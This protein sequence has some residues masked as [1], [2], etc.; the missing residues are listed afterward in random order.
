MCVAMVLTYFATAYTTSRIFGLLAWFPTPAM[1]LVQPIYYIGRWIRVRKQL[2]NHPELSQQTGAM[3]HSYPTSVN[4]KLAT[5]MW[6]AE[7]K[8]DE[9]LHDIGTRLGKTTKALE[10]IGQSN[11]FEGHEFTVVLK[12]KIDT[13]LK[14]MHKLHGQLKEQKQQLMATIE[15]YQLQLSEVIAFRDVILAAEIVDDNDAFLTKIETQMLH[16]EH[17][18]KSALGQIQHD[19]LSVNMLVKSLGEVQELYPAVIR[20]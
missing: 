17:G 9:L 7:S 12:Q 5:Y 6:Y 2:K 18:V 4:A 15:N 10:A 8:Y 11:P 13:Q 1:P 20:S 14:Q 16:L 3:A 19:E